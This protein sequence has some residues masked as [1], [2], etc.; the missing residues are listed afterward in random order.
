MT[1]PS[2]ES[3]YAFRIH[4]E[5]LVLRIIK[6][7]ITMSKEFKLKKKKTKKLDVTVKGG[8]T[9]TLRTL[10]EAEAFYF[11][12]TLG[13][14]TGQYARSLQEFLDNIESIKPESLIFHQGRNDFKNWI[15]NTLEDSKL[16]Q[17]IETIPKEHNSQ[18]RKKIRAA[19]KARL[20]ELEGISIQ[21][22]EPETTYSPDSSKVAK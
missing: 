2:A 22:L 21:I 17:K 12:E 3:K 18:I 7:T 14:P 10:Q 6:F 16:A 8:A 5:Y 20:Q 4:K 11:Y 19:V 1:G 13:K 9:R 15:A